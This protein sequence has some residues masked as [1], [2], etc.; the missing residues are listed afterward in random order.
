MKHSDFIEI[1]RTLKQIELNEMK[2]AIK[3]HGGCYV[4]IEPGADDFDDNL[5]HCYASNSSNTEGA[6]EILVHRVEYDDDEGIVRVYGRD[7]Y[8]EKYTYACDLQ[9]EAGSFHE[10]MDYMDDPESEED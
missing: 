2:E 10:I 1:Y 7:F 5:P 4:F 6:A 8:F 3:A 9:V